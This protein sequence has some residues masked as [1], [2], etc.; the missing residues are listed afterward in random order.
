VE[1]FIRLHTGI[2]SYVINLKFFFWLAK[3]FS[4]IYRNSRFISVFP[5]APSGCN[6]DADESQ[7]TPVIPVTLRSKKRSLRRP[8]K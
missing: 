8:L 7:H 5:R 6:P 1:V 2:N 4:A 3:E